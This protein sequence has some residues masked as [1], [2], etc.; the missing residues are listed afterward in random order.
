[1]YTNQ[2]GF[3]HYLTEPQTVV[4][5]GIP[6]QRDCVVHPAKYPELTLGSYNHRFRRLVEE[7]YIFIDRHNGSRSIGCTQLVIEER[8]LPVPHRTTRPVPDF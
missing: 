2:K 7:G 6:G 8:E 4:A 3:Y 1:V 5:I